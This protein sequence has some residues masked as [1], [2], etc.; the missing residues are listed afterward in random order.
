MLLYE[1][2]ECELNNSSSHAHV[3]LMICCLFT[4]SC[5]ILAF[6]GG[7][8]L[9]PPAKATRSLAIPSAAPGA[10]ASACC[11]RSLSN[12]PVDINHQRCFRN[13]LEKK[14]NNIAF[15]L[16]ARGQCDAS[17]YAY[18]LLEGNRWHILLAPL[19]CRKYAN[20]KLRVN[21]NWNLDFNLFRRLSMQK[22]SSTPYAARWSGLIALSCVLN[23]VRW[24]ARNFL[25]YE[26]VPNQTFI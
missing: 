2:I 18:L 4:A 19:C 16:A 13:K 3:V 10:S 7:N 15:E 25:A 14:W 21:M 20:L 6:V 22:V 5:R 9:L 1:F 8:W 24:I 12:N 11:P 23:G 26:R 17:W